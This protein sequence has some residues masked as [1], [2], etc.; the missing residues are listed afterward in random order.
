MVVGGGQIYAQLIDKADKLILTEVH[1]E[2]DGDV[3]FPEIDPTKWKKVAEKPHKEFS[4]VTYER[5]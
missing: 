1:R 5:I 4:W 2:I 3:M